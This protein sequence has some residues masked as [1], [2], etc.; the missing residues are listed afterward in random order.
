MH[1]T[2]DRC[3]YVVRAE[4]LLARDKV[5][6]ESVESSSTGVCEEKSQLEGSQHSER[7]FA[8]KMKDL[9]CQNVLPGDGW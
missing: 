8:G 1:A 3:F 9:H 5:R 7:T 4:M 6:D 2:E